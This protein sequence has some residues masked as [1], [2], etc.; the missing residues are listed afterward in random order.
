MKQTEISS[1]EA[2]E[3]AKTIAEYCTDRDATCRCCFGGC[4]FDLGDGS[5]AFMEK[6]NGE[7]APCTWPIGKCSNSPLLREQPKRQNADH[8]KD[9]GLTAEEVTFICQAV[10]QYADSSQWFS[11]I[12]GAQERNKRL[13][14]SVSVKVTNYFYGG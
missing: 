5:C 1:Q 8:K 14:D 12:D 2:L 10:C 3:A 6:E 13:R 9:I 7:W 11:L 4:V